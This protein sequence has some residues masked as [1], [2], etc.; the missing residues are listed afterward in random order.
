[1][2]AEAG[3]HLPKSPSAATIP[4][5]I[6]IRRGKELAVITRTEIKFNSGLEDSFFEMQKVWAFAWDPYRNP[7]LL[8]PSFRQRSRK[9]RNGPKG[10]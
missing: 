9:G 8:A 3:P 2:P 4:M 1:V 10:G 5:R 7:Y 6:L